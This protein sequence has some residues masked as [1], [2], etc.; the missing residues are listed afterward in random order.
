MLR[1]LTLGFPTPV[2]TSCVFYSRDYP[3]LPGDV[4]PYM[5][6]ILV[7]GYMSGNSSETPSTSFL[8]LYFYF[9]VLNLFSPLWP[10]Q[11]PDF[12]LC[13]Y[14]LVSSHFLSCSLLFSPLLLFHCSSFLPLLP[15]FPLT[16]QLYNVPC[17][18]FN[19]MCSREAPRSSITR[20]LKVFWRVAKTS[21]VLALNESNT[22][23]ESLDAVSLTKP[24]GQFYSWLLEETK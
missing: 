11:G 6:N 15:L 4:L 12:T 5:L 23:G 7:G 21:R 22:V 24:L 2:S 3:V 14:C 18:D 1:F 16:S 17:L 13:C 9:C 8:H 19:G 20:Q 10:P